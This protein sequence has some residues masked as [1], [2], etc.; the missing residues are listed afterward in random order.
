MEVGNHL[1]AL[2]FGE[3]CLEA[4]MEPSLRSYLHA[5]LSIMGR[6]L[7]G[8]GRFGP[9]ISMLTE[10]AQQSAE[11]GEYVEQ[12]QAE[13]MLAVASVV[14]NRVAHPEFPD[15][16]CGVVKQGGEQPPCQFSW[17][18]D[19]AS[20][21]P[22]EADSWQLAQSLAQRCLARAPRDATR[23]ALFFHEASIRNP[24]RRPRE[25]TVQIGHHVFY[26]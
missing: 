24:W 19:G 15:S 17:W 1:S 7:S 22:T 6:A 18:C 12:T 3:A 8:W 10:A 2:E 13:G 4:A 5:P 16:V 26:R 25:R 20:D 9:S 23:G 21:R 11:A 14:L